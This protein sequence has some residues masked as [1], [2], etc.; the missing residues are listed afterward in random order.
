MR[1]TTYCTVIGQ[2]NLAVIRKVV[3]TMSSE[4]RE[5]IV[6]RRNNLKT[7]VAREGRQLAKGAVEVSREPLHDL[8]N[9][10]LDY[11]LDWVIEKVTGSAS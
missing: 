1:S 2:G 7:T 5:L 3:Q 6:T 8:G 11:F 4:N 10:L 9:N